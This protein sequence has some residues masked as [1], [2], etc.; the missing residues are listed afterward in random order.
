MDYYGLE[1][2]NKFICPKCSGKDNDQEKFIS[3]TDA[4]AGIIS[5]H[6]DS[7]SLLCQQDLLKTTL[8][9]ETM[10]VEEEEFFNCLQEESVEV[11]NGKSKRYHFRP[12]GSLIQFKGI[13][14]L[15]K[16][17]VDIYESRHH[18]NATES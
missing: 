15:A 8:N 18:E 1:G 14:T 3:S 2:G 9:D 11:I 5:I 17:F 6:A 13:Y 7:N 16:K 10:L 4:D 12:K